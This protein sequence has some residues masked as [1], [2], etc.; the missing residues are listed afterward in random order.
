MAEHNIFGKKGEEAATYIL[1]QK[2]YLIRDRNWRCGKNEI[3]IVA[4]KGERIIF[5]EVKTRNQEIEDISQVITKQKINHLINAG[6]AYVNFFKIAKEMQ[7]DVILLVG[8]DEADFSIEHIE[9]AFAA[10]LKTY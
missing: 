10:P 2:G 3:D 7:F 5:V 4:E 9:D 6:N 8:N 1:L